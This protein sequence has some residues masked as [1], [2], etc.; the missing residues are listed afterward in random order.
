MPHD[1]KDVIEQ[2]GTHSYDG[3]NSHNHPPRAHSPLFHSFEGVDPFALI[4]DSR[5]KA[6]DAALCI[7]RL[8]IAK[9]LCFDNAELRTELAQ[10]VG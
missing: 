4:R 3:G 7:F 1:F 10:F 2:I 8:V 6:R 5:L 9:E